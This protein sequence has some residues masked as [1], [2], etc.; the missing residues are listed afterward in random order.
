MLER[1]RTTS[2]MTMEIQD[3]RSVLEGLQHRDQLVLLR[4]ANNE[5]EINESA[6]QAYDLLLEDGTSVVFPEVVADL[7]LELVPMRVNF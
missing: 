7:Q 1:Q 4:L 5:V 3:R 2:A 6:Q